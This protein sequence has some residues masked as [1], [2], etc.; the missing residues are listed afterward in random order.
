VTRVIFPA[1][2][3]DDHPDAEKQSGVHQDD[4]DEEATTP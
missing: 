4:R 1:E 3:W 2:F